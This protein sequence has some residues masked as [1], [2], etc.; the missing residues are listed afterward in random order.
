MLRAHALKNSDRSRPM[1]DLGFKPIT[2]QELAFAL[3]AS[4]ASLRQ[5]RLKKGAKAWRSP[6]DDCEEA[7]ACLAESHGARLHRLADAPNKE[8]RKRRRRLAEGNLASRGA[9]LQRLREIL[10]AFP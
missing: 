5:A 1:Q 6:P 7:V 4:V 9:A 10:R 2:H 3:E 8:L